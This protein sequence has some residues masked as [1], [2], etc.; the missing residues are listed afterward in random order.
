MSRWYARFAVG[1][2]A[3]AVLVGRAGIAN[4]DTIII[5]VKSN[6]FSPSDVTVNVGDTVQWVIDEDVH[7]T[8]S[9]TGLWD[10]GVLSAGSTFEYTF[11]DPGD[12]PFICTL[13]FNCCNMAG[14]VHVQTAP[15]P[16]TVT[17]YSTD[18]I[19]DMDPSARFA[20]PFGAST[21]AWF[22]AG[23]V[24]D[25][26]VQHHDGLPAGLSFI[27]ATGSGATYQI[28]PAAAAGQSELT[29]SSETQ[30]FRSVARVGVNS[31]PWM[32]NGK[33]HGPISP[34]KRSKAGGRCR[35]TT[36]TAATAAAT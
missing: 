30:Y 36:R 23:A 28:Q 22:E 6:F 11:N 5:D 15:A 34:V 13:H 3:M 4:A 26:G 14:S 19:S 27:S 32:P 12:F 9:S 16:I 29:G 7:T 35:R 18:V 31:T 25:S 10:S 33:P 21:F 8:T 2:A 17:G 20:Q 24:D 1:V